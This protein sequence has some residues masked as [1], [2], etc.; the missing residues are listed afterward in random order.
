MSSQKEPDPSPLPQANAAV[1]GKEAAERVAYYFALV[2][3]FCI[4]GISIAF[5]AIL[6]FFYYYFKVIFFFFFFLS[7][8]ERRPLTLDEKILI[9]TTSPDKFG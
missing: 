5:G 3:S 4:T 2:F 7:I 8:G 1:K 6:V 9:A